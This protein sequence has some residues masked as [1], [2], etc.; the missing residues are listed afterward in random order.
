MSDSKILVS[1]IIPY[2]KKKLFIIKTI[3][4]VLKQS[5]KNLEIIIIYDDADLTDLKF[6]KKI[7]K[8]NNRIKIYQNKKNMGVSKSRNLGIKKSKGKYIAFIDSDDLWKKNKLKFQLNFMR[9]KKCLISH[10]DYDIINS[11]NK[12]LGYM[13]VKKRLTYN[14]LIYS[15]D[16]GLSTVM[17]SKKLKLKAIFP[18]IITKEDYVLWL[19]LSKKFNIYGIQKNLGSW[20]KSDPSLSYFWQKIKDAF[21]LYSKYEKFNLFKSLF[22]VLLL[23]LNSIKKSL[24]QKIF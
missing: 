3:N 14:D 21:T 5:H 22:F 15:C 23:S 20:R 24:L 4:S 7:I 12:F 10:T 6:L 18:N 11:K 19:K 2:Y 8:K 9:K 17:I 13:K 1:I 16:I